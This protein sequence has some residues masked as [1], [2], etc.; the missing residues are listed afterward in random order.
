MT[1]TEAENESGSK[2]GDLL[3]DSLEIT[4][5]RTFGHLKIDRL[6]RVNLIVGKNGVG[7]STVLEAIRLYADGG[8]P[9]TLENILFARQ[10][11]ERVVYR[12]GPTDRFGF[13]LRSVFREIDT[14]STSAFIGMAPNVIIIA[15][16]E[17]VK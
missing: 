5:F 16:R 9:R 15:G 2:A 1:T 7:K 13:V 12:G 8:L 10:E 6:G 14:R 3:L 17:I 11:I 4:N